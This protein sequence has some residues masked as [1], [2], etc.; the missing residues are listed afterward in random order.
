MNSNPNCVNVFGKER[1]FTLYLDGFLQA[2]G[3]KLAISEMDIREDM[4]R[5]KEVVGREGGLGLG[6]GWRMG[7]K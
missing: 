1:Q 7:E 3:Y 4:R 6:L 5:M 2:A